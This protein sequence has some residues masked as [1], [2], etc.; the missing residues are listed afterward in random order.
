MNWEGFS[1]HYLGLNYLSMT[2]CDET[3]T[4]IRRADKAIEKISGIRSAFGA[5]TNRLEKMYDMNQT[6]K[7]N[8]QYAESRIRDADMAKE[9]ME[10]IK[11]NVLQ[12]A[13]QTLLLQSVHLPERVLELLQ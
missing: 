8:L 6:Y 7:E 4:L 3:S 11:W 13:S 5:Y 9:I 10:H 12:Q 1:A 2:N